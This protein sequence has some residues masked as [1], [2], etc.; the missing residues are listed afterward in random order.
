MRNYQNQLRNVSE[1]LLEAR[2]LAGSH[3]FFAALVLST[4]HMH[5]ALFLPFCQALPITTAWS[6]VAQIS[7]YCV[8]QRFEVCINSK[9]FCFDRNIM[10]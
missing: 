10:V 4:Q 3:N 6:T 2:A 7:S 5:L 8:F 1:L 9:D